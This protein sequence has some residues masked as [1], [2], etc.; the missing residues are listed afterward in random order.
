MLD[1]SRGRLPRTLAAAALVG[2]AI[3]LCAC[4]SDSPGNAF[5][6]PPTPTV[7]QSG[8][9]TPAPT[10]APIP[11]TGLAASVNGTPITNKQYAAAVQQEIAALTYQMQQQGGQ[12]PP[13][14]QVRS[15]V[16]NNILIDQ[17]VVDKYAHD[18]G[19]TVSLAEVA[20]Q[21]NAAVVQNGGLITL[22]NVLKNYGLTPQT[23]RHQIRN[24]IMQQR[25]MNRVVPLAPV[26]EAQARHILVK[27]KA[28]ADRLANQI[29][30]GA[31]FGQLAKTY[32]IDNGVQAQPGVTLTAQQKQQAQ[33]RSSAYNGGWLRDPTQ[34]VVKNQPSWLTPQTGFVKPVLDA[35]LSM[36]PGDVR[37]VKSQF[38]YHVIQVTAHRAVPVSQL[39]QQTQQTYATQQQQSFR[40]WIV[41]QRKQDN[42]KVF[43]KGLPPSPVA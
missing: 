19:I 38:G 28:L 39:D 4:V 10:A 41:T 12:M 13:E 35:V 23:A 17:I 11:S 42:V 6:P 5:G 30:N 21:F 27:S 8:L 29:H 3:S 24:S 7:N 25:V 2:V 26:Q 43:V 18:H 32:S 40:H 14:L 37:V 15:Y 31:N 22:T 33:S 36:K 34:P 20:K 1:V 16:L 9:P